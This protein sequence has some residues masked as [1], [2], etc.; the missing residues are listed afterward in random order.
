MLD[1]EKISQAVKEAE[2]MASEMGIAISTAVVD[3]HGDLLF[4][5]RMPGALVVS[6]KF[7]MA[8]AYTAAVFKMPNHGMAD[9]VAEGKPY[10]GLSSLDAKF[11]TIAGGLPIMI[12]G[13]FVGAVGIGGSPDP[14]QDEKLAERV[15]AILQG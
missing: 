5:R 6:P 1:L 15:T 8:K 4:F 2:N 9:F 7:A 13:E 14:N 11:T 3:E 10:Y 12:D